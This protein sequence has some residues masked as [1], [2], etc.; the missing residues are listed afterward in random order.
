MLEDLGI[1]RKQ[2]LETQNQIAAYRLRLKRT[3][4]NWLDENVPHGGDHIKAYLQQFVV[5]ET[6]K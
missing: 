6:Q 2:C 1:T 5:K 3:K 4:G